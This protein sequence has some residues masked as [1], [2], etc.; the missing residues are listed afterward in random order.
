MSHSSPAPAATISATWSS[1]P[2]SPSLLLSLLFLSFLL[3]ADWLVEK[4]H[5]QL[6]VAHAGGREDRPSKQ[7]S[8]PP[9][10]EGRVTKL[11]LTHTHIIPHRNEGGAV[12]H[13]LSSSCQA[14][15][16]PLFYRVEEEGAVPACEHLVRNGGNEVLI[17][18]E[19]GGKLVDNLMKAVQKLDENRRKF[20]A[21][22]SPLLLSKPVRK[23]VSERYPLLFNHIAK[24]AKRTKVWI[25]HDLDE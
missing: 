11:L 22:S 7:L 13:L 24:S 21:I 9:L 4:L 18:L 10:V 1:P 3:L 12:V 14:I 6:Q 23:F 17:V 25:E 20:V 19:C 8:V 16:L 2:F 15:H 5:P